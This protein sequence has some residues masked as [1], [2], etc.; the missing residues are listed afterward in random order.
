MDMHSIGLCAIALSC[1]LE[2]WL[3]PTS[4]FFA[5]YG[6]FSVFSKQSVSAPS[7]SPSIVCVI[8]NLETGGS[9][10]NLV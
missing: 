10:C 7:F 8:T 3:L 9:S 5:S 2:V 6:I 4:L 1:I